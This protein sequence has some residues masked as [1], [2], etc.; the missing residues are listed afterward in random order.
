VQE[1]LGWLRQRYCDA[2][3][4]EPL[5]TALATHTEIPKVSFFVME[6]P[7]GEDT[8]ADYYQVEPVNRG[9][10]AKCPRCS[11]GTRLVWLPPYRAELELWGRKWSD[12]CFGGAS[13]LLVS[14]RFRQWYRD[15]G[16]TGMEGFHPVEI[17]KVRRHKAIL[18]PQP[19]YYIVTVPTSN[20]AIDQAASGLDR[21]DGN[22][23]KLPVC[24]DCRQGGLMLRIRRVILEPDTWSGEDVFRAR[25]LS[26]IIVT[27][28]FQQLAV[29]GGIIGGLFVPA[30]EYQ[31]DFYPSRNAH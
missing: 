22:L 26:A 1:V 14:D 30:S 28:R 18:G 15:A 5:P 6:C 17:T 11:R 25:G 29:E 9:P 4:K 8:Q 7:A 16:L 21:R 10:A 13:A 12:I 3:F 23:D 31:I 2:D 19:A 24:P 20:A 27:S